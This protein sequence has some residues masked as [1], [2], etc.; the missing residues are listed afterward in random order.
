MLS[1]NKI[2][3]Y[4]VQQQHFQIV[5]QNEEEIQLKAGT[6]TDDFAILRKHQIPL[7]SSHLHAVLRK[8]FLFIKRQ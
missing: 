2:I 5:G 7:V 3:K 8:L 1:P 4:R 6:S